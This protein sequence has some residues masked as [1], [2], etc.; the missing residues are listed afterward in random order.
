MNSA[1]AIGVSGVLWLV[2]TVLPRAAY[3]GPPGDDIDALNPEQAQLAQ[4]M[5]GFVRDTEADFFA[6]VS[7]LN[8][9]APVQSRSFEFDDADYTVKV[10]RGEVVEKA[11]FTVSMTKKAIKP[12]TQ[13]A[14]WSRTVTI[15]IHPKTPLVGFLHAFIAFQY[16]P[17]GK[18]S[19][20]GSMDIVPGTRNE[21]D[22]TFIK[23]AVERVF[24]KHG[25]DITNYRKVVS[26]G[27]RIKNLKAA[28]IGVSFYA[29]PFL[30]ITQENFDLVTETFETFID[31]YIEVLEKRKNQPHTSE[32]LA[33]QDV[34]R[35]RW[36]EDQMI[37][38]PY[39]IKVIPFAVRSWANFPPETKY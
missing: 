25:A 28:R 37:Y 14:L 38:D 6:T 33:A 16:N 18:S 19:M 3:P 8:G 24:E 35:V 12:Y 21:E 10:T 22:L 4:T 27:Q 1:K 2:L 17:D 29:R 9:A 15:D 26:S 34:M 23:E 5:L 7:R 20:G 31:A 11:G 36:L 39:A 13:D 30:D 32:D